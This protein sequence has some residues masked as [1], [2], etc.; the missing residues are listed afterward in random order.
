M[1]SRGAGVRNW[2]VLALFRSARSRHKACPRLHHNQQTRWLGL[3][4]SGHPI[5]RSVATAFQ[6]RSQPIRML[7]ME[8]EST[9]IDN[10]LIIR[11][12]RF[13][14]ARGFFA[15][16]YLHAD[17][18]AAGAGHDWVQENQSRSSRTGTVR[19]L[20]FQRP[21][22]SQA[23]L[24]RV[25]HGA[26]LDVCVDLR[27]GSPTFGRHLAVELSAE[28]LAQVYVPPGFAHGFCTLTDDV[29]VL[30]K[31]S[32]PWSPEH[33]GG[34]MWNDP[35]LGISWPVSADRAVISLRDQNWPSFARYL[36]TE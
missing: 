30:Y 16:I 1:P 23:K 11:P 18:R 21:P 22:F 19:G 10:V 13:E 3:V 34:L 35:E 36:E 27:R 24:V 28:N 32:A 26:A 31:V 25:V 14:D 12:K 33:E 17:L 5:N 20:H 9:A 2:H 29:D 15:P 8:I 6:V 7:A 4:G